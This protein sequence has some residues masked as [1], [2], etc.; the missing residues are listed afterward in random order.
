MVN[1]TLLD[2]VLFLEN[3]HRVNLGQQK[4]VGLD[5]SDK[6]LFELH[7]RKLTWL[8]R[9]SPFSIEKTSSNCRCSI[10]MLVF[11]KYMLVPI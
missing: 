5:G 3:G 10:A 9:K 8:A 6:F 2:A 1:Q 7:S 4:T 11:G